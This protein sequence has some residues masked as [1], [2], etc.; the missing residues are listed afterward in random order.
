[1][2][3]WI[4]LTLGV[5]ALLGGIAINLVGCL[6]RGRCLFVQPP[7]EPDTRVQLTVGGKRFTTLLH[8]REDETLWLVPPLQMGL[9]IAF[10]EGSVG[11]LEVAL[12]TGLYRASIQFLGRRTNPSL[13][14]LRLS[15]AWQHTQR[16]HHE[17]IPLPDEVQVEVQTHQE[18]WIGW[19][20]DVSHGGMCLISPVD[21]S[22]GTSLHLTLPS[23]LAQGASS[24]RW[25]R[26]VACRRAVHRA[27][28]AYLVHLAYT[29][30]PVHT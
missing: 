24:E 25:A 26:V 17:R 27:G 30:A 13:I 18:R 8:H 7:L 3:E 29:D 11:T 9:P 1:M 16:R 19:V 2:N 4:L 22:G 5:I 12:P 15:S 23:A 21:F 6:A 10:P 14:G 28:Y 20:R